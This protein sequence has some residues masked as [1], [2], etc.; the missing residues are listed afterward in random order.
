MANQWGRL[1]YEWAHD[2]KVQTMTE[3]DQRRHAMLLCMHIEGITDA[4]DS[5]V[6]FYMRIGLEDW[7]QTKTVF[8]ERGFLAEDGS[9]HL[10]NWERRQY[11]SDSSAERMARHRQKKQAG[12]VSE[13]SQKRFT[14]VT[15]ETSHD[16]HK[17][18]TVTPPDTETDTETEEESPPTPPR[19]GE[20]ADS[21][22]PALASKPGNQEP[23]LSAQVTAAYHEILPELPK[24]CLWSSQMILDLTHN[25]EIDP[26]RLLIG[27]W[28]GLFKR[29]RDLPALMG[30][31]KETRAR[32]Q[33]FKASLPR[34]L[35]PDNVAKILNGYYSEKSAATTLSDERIPPRA[36]RKIGA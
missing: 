8:I 19:G 27:F 7:R 32:G 22:K 23:L 20:G 3:A 31:L 18:V 6:A 28:R 15:N 29:V 25:G 14:S 12:D 17:A 5:D 16:R 30:T 1:Y 9:N 10:T 33:P 34:L 4:A 21:G 13:P 35:K 26:E 11:K 24:V 2:L 36:V